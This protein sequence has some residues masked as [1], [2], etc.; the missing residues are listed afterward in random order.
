MGSQRILRD[1]LW[2]IIDLDIPVIRVSVTLNVKLLKVPQSSRVI[3][4]PVDD[5]G[6][7]CLTLNPPTLSLSYLHLHPLYLSTTSTYTVKMVSSRQPR[8]R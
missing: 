6:V 4:Y 3:Q 7:D 5:G 2:T 8:Y 1:D